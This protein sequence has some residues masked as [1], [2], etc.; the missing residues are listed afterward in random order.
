MDKHKLYGLPETAM[1]SLK[2]IFL[3]DGRIENVWLYGS[4][5]TGKQK[6]ASDI[7]LCIEGAN[8]S[9]TDLH[10]L[11]NEIDDLLLPWKIDLSL[12][13]QIDN[14]ALLKHITDVGINI[15]D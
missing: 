2:K 11:E 12:I 10:A 14:P 6:P 13:H 15:L 4:R 7:D 3:Q 9:L 1:Q 5:A 8:L